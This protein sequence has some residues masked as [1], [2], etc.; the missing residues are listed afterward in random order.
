MLAAEP[1]PRSFAAGAEI[2]REGRSPERLMMVKNSM[3]RRATEGTALAPAFEGLTGSTAL[4]FGGEDIISLAKEVTII[5]A[6][7]NGFLD[8][9]P[10]EN[11]RQ[12]EN[13]FHRFMETA[14][15]EII[16]TVMKDK[17]LSDDTISALKAA[18]DEFKKQVVI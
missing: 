7:T 16:E 15:P 8:D 6:L 13:D 2:V 12:W 17:A 4:L 5:Y 14:H 10:I 3:V 11:V 1:T 18:I 9:V